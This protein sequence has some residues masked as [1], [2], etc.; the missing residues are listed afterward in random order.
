VATRRSPAPKGW[1]AIGN[2]DG[3]RLKRCTATNDKEVRC[4]KEL[5]FSLHPA[6]NIGV[7]SSTTGA[8]TYMMIR[9]SEDLRLIISTPKLLHA[10]RGIVIFGALV[11]R[12]PGR[13]AG[14]RL[15][16]FAQFAGNEQFSSPQDP[17]P[18]DRRPTAG[19][20]RKMRCTSSGAGG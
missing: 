15:E 4:T 2:G 20:G 12:G 7:D 6:S 5:R 3:H 11:G 8:K 16:L 17:T 13:V 10:W 1:E 9:G 18:V 19:E 14:N